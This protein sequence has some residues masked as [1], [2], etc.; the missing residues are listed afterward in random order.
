MRRISLGLSLALCAGVLMHA[1]CGEQ[2]PPAASLL[3]QGE[4]YYKDRKLVEALDQFKQFVEYYPDSTQAGRCAFMVGFIYANDFQDTLNARKAYTAF[5]K[6]F[7]AADA[8]LRG[9]AE[10]ELKHLGQDIS[11]LDF[12]APPSEGTGEP[13][14]P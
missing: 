2:K 5:L 11:T 6:D 1:G 7:P 9:S 8:G 13:Q 3:Q 12:L 4:A 14:K 10:W